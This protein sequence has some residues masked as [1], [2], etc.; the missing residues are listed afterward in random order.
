MQVW[1]DWLVHGT[2]PLDVSWSSVSI[3][4]DILVVLM[5]HWVLGRSPLAVRVGHW[6]VL[7]E[8]SADDPLSE[9]WVVEQCL[10]VHLMII[11]HDWTVMQKTTA[12]TSDDEVHA[13]EVCNPATGVEILYWELTDHEETKSNSNLGPGGII[14]EVEV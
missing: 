11:H 8:N 3:S 9:I 13:V 1:H 2:V 12:K 4:V 5:I 7:W 6:W 14:C 10:G